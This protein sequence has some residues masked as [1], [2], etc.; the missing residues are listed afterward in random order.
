MG[1]KYVTMFD[2]LKE[3]LLAWTPDLTDKFYNGLP[4]YSE[5][6]N[7]I[8]EDTDTGFYTI[9][10]HLTAFY[11]F[12]GISYM[13]QESDRT[14][15]IEQKIALSKYADDNNL[16]KIEMP[17]S[18]EVIEIYGTPYTYSVHRRPYNSLGI[19]AANLKYNTLGITT[20]D[21][22]HQFLLILDQLVLSIDTIYNNKSAMNYPTSVNFFNICYD[23]STESFF[24]AG[25]LSFDSPR[26]DSTQINEVNNWLNDYEG[27]TVDMQTDIIDFIEARCPT[28]HQ[29]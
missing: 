12:D 3:K 10:P 7:T 20:K 4:R 9:S 5:F 14:R 27:T 19:P 22:L 25:C 11:G 2:I 1:N 26:H 18:V 15:E 23:E 28:L 8:W 13:L 17:I 21:A 16:I 24:L 6:A 29:R